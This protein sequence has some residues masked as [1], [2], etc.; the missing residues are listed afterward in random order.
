MKRAI[1]SELCPEKPECEAMCRAVE[2][3]HRDRDM[4]LAPLAPKPA[5]RSRAQS[6]AS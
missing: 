6:L 3:Y 2:G 1:E 4:S 5:K